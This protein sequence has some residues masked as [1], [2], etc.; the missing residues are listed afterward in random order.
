MISFIILLFSP[1]VFSFDLCTLFPNLK[2]CLN[3]NDDSQTTP[4]EIS[5]YGHGHIEKNMTC[6]CR[7]EWQGTH[8][9]Q[10]SKLSV[11]SINNNL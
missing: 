7:S 3:K 6:I 5:C 2:I 1:L 4:I 9:E 10:E 8:C 11:F